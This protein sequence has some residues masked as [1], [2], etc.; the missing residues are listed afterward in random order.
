[1]PPKKEDNVERGK[2]NQI[3]GR[4]GEKKFKKILEN[5]GFKDVID[6]NEIEINYPY[7]DF[8][9]KYKGKLYCIQLKTD[10]NNDGSTPDLDTEH[11]NE[12]INYAKS[13]EGFPMLAKFYYPDNKKKHYIKTFIIKM[14]KNKHLEKKNLVNLKWVF[15]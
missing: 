5:S 7:V 10:A 12:L 13:K 8:E 14:V 4:I 9:A 3:G 11:A 6:L 1:M 15:E 2:K